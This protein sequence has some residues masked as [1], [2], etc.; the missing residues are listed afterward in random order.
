MNRPSE[1]IEL[2]SRALGEGFIFDVTHQRGC[3]IFEGKECS[4]DFAIVVSK[5]SR[6]TRVSGH[7][8]GLTPSPV[9]CLPSVRGKDDTGT[10]AGLQETITRMEY[11]NEL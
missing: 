1:K 4:C 5:Q 10:V 3:G 8:A 2:M 6:D 7:G 11:P 9:S